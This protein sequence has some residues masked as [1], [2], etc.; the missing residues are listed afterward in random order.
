M[1]SE[2]LLDT[3]SSVEKETAKRYFLQM[4]FMLVAL[5]QLLDGELH[6]SGFVSSEPNN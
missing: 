2:F 1:V 6:L 4:G 5:R 3:P